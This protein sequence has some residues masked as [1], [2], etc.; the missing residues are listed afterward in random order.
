M[1]ALGKTTHEEAL[2]GLGAEDREQLVDA[3]LK[4]RGNLSVHGG[5]R[6]VATLFAGP[7]PR[8]RV[9]HG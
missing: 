3:L 5:A 1:W 2:A 7:E 6:D 8:R 9:R 4:I